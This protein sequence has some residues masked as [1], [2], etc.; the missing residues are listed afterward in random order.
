MSNRCPLQSRPELDRV[1]SNDREPPRELRELSTKATTPF[2]A[3]VSVYSYM[4]REE[5]RYFVCLI[6][7][8]N[9]SAIWTSRIRSVV[10][11]G[12]MYTTQPSKS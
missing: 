10:L 6:D 5:V 3:E 1:L 12:L 4:R 9:T 8:V 2:M 7:D 11:S